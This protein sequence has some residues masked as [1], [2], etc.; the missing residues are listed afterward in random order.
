M[1]V[2]DIQKQEIKESSQRWKLP[3]WLDALSP[4]P[5]ARPGPPSLASRPQA[6]ALGCCLKWDHRWLPK[7][8]LA[9]GLARVQLSA[10]GRQTW[11]GSH[12][13]LP[14]EPSLRCAAQMA[15]AHPKICIVLLTGMEM[16][17]GNPPAVNEFSK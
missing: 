1:L 4:Q 16:G 11:K 17:G 7:G 5:T 14:A 13:W 9:P 8:S 2:E 10:C 12:S 15:C 6:A 3:E